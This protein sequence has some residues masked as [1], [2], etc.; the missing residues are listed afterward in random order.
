[1]RVVVVTPSLPLAFGTADAR[2]LHVVVTE[3]ARR[4]HA[5][6]CVS[7]TEELDVRVGAAQA[8][9]DAHGFRLRHVPLRLTEPALAR[10]VRSAVRPFS[11]YRRVEPLMRAIDEEA[12]TADVLHIEHLFPSWVAENRDD[13]LTFLHHLEIIDWEERTD[14]DRRERATFVQMQRATRRLLRDST[15][16]IAA[17]SRLAERVGQIAPGVPAEVVPVSIDPSCYPVL[18]PVDAPVV[19]IIGSMHWY[20]SRSAA[21]RVLTRL[22]PQI[23]RAVPGARLL[24]AGWGAE[25]WLGPLFP[26]RGAELLGSVE[27]PEDFFSQISVLLYPPARG[28][29]MKIKALEAMAYGRPVVSNTEGLEG[30]TD[31]PLPVATPLDDDT[32]L[33]DRTIELLSDPAE[34]S[35][36]GD[37]GRQLIEDV[38][39]PEPAVDRLVA[40]Y[41][42][43]GIGAAAGRTT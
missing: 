9:A 20:P 7:C 26:V 38:Y 4:G 33:I 39:S 16:L 15:H 43:L 31:R 27:R 14:L 41:Q 21:E 1:M 17:T 23:E 19:G 30:L 22:W 36:L 34:R 40:A 25:E 3:L 28:S 32:T 2:W 29:G 10:K 5:V 24:V 11:E 8:S 13:S 12:A 37:A 18:P 6:T 42:R 35:A